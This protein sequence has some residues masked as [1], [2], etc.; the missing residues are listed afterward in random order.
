MPLAAVSAK[1]Y[2]PRMESAH[3]VI[4]CGGRDYADRSAIWAALDRFSEKFGIAC[5]I[6]GAAR[7]VDTI[8]GEWAQSRGIAVNPFPANWRDHGKAAGPM[9]N[10]QMLEEGNPTA[11]IGFPGGRGTENMLSQARAKGIKVYRPKA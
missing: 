1:W 3:R 7:G 9:R 10:R 6:H 4:V 2:F 5:V 11:V 8:A